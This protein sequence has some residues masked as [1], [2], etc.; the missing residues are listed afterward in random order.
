MDYIDYSTRN[1][2]LGLYVAHPAYHK[3]AL[4]LIYDKG[5]GSKAFCPVD[6][7]EVSIEDAHIVIAVRVHGHKDGGRRMLYIKSV[8]VEPYVFIALS[9]TWES[10]NHFF[11][12]TIGIL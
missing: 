5:I 12:L 11:N 3:S 9:G 4:A 7:Q 8:E 6:N 2:S 1:L 10:C